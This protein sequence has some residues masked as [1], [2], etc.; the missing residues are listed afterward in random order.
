MMSPGTGGDSPTQEEPAG[1]IP[2]ANSERPTSTKRI[3]KRDKQPQ[4]RPPAFGQPK[5]ARSALEGVLLVH[6]IIDQPA[7]SWIWRAFVNRLRTS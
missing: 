5:P 7:T 2:G 1:A 3:R 4:P 6:A